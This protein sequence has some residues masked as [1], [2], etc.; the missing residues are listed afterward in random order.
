MPAGNLMS[1]LCFALTVWLCRSKCRNMR[2]NVWC[3]A[4][5]V[6]LDKP[7]CGIAVASASVALINVVTSAA[8]DSM[9]QL[10]VN[11]PFL[12]KRM[13]EVAYDR[14]IARPEDQKHE[15]LDL[16][17]APS[18]TGL[19]PAFIVTAEFDPLRDEGEQYAS[20]LSSSGVQVSAV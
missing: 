18:M 3:L 9:E 8:T 13:L 20:R 2:N 7:M 11:A 6:H 5:L 17:H 10:A 15:L 1:N 12:S 14:L 4:L 19:P 16:I